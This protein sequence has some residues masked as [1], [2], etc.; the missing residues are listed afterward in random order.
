MKVAPERVRDVDLCVRA[1]PSK[2][3]THRALIAAALAGGTSVI[4]GPLRSEDT[5][6]TRRALERFG[7]AIWDDGGDLEVEGTGGDLRC[8]AGGPIDCGNSGTSMRLLAPLALL[9]PHP[10]VF[11]GTERMRQRPIGPLVDA[12][13]RIGGA[14]TYEQAPGFP[15]IRVSGT[16]AGGQT[17]VDA[18]VS[19]Q[20]VSSVLLAAPMAAGPVEVATVGQVS[21]R[22]Y[23]D[24]TVDVMRAFGVKVA[25]DGDAWFAVDPRPYRPRSYAIEGD[26]SSAS[27]F[28]AMA[29]VSGGR[30]TVENLNPV[31]VQG[32]RRFV[33]ALGR[34]G[35][36]VRARPGGV[37]VTRTGRLVGIEIDMA[38]TPDTVQTL[39]AVAAFADSPTTI[40]G[41]GHLRHKESDRIEA[42][43]G[44][45]R[46]CGA[47]AAWV[48][49]TLTITPGP[50][51]GCT[52]DP[53]NDHRTAMAA[54]VIALGAGG[55]TIEGAECVAKSFPEFWAILQEAGLV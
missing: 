27:Y 8:R 42:T 51:R 49:D 32:D 16:L 9:C 30:V 41:I 35:C 20:F 39:A 37:T 14:I 11:T 25:R 17:S 5:A 55:V 12:L 31:S 54:A 3:Y 48:Q 52:I 15:P 10:V 36:E 18:S 7:I 33:A 22:S 47:G 1:P 38:S 40:S 50:F 29:A 23:L 53:R 44:M 6:L 21:S 4:K 19:S 43:V 28:F 13:N 26:Y 2:S 24:V 45:L 34:M 46:A